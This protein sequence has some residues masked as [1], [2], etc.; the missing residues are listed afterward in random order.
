MLTIEYIKKA[1]QAIVNK[2]ILRILLKDGMPYSVNNIL[3]L[4]PKYD[5]Q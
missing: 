4:W 5:R 1:E 3:S 2:L